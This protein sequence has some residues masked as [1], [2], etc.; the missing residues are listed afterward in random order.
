MIKFNKDTDL[1]YDISDGQKI[2][3]YSR[4]F[5]SSVVPID[6]GD[7]YT[8]KKNYIVATFNENNKCINA[9]S[10]GFNRR[11]AWLKFCELIPD[12][13]KEQYS[14]E[15]ETEIYN[16]YHKDDDESEEIDKLLSNLL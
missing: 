12:I 15:K 16:F 5:C 10:F 1:Y 3:V 7:D 11:D 6:D 2:A 14:E 13:L 4:T 9:Q 8:N